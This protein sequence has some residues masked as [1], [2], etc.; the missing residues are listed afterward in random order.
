MAI[1]TRE[2]LDDIAHAKRITRHADS[3]ND[4]ALSVEDEENVTHAISAAE[5]D[6]FGMI[7]GEWSVADI[8]ANAFI[9]EITA[10]RAL[11]YLAHRNPPLSP[12]LQTLFEWT[13]HALRDLRTGRRDLWD[14]SAVLARAKPFV[15][16]TT[17]DQ[18]PIFHATEYD[19][20]GEEMDDEKTGTLD[21][22]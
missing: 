12:Q 19:V 21:N 5:S 9:E 8:E 14:G 6:V 1:I 4:G 2:Q 13:G 7:G 22:Y 15:Q 10:I 16:S 18:Q 3:D 17:E 20:D 11:Y